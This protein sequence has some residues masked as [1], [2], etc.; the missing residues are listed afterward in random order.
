M[1]HHIKVKRD[2]EWHSWCNVCS[3]FEMGHGKDYCRLQDKAI[4]EDVHLICSF[5]T[6]EEAQKAIDF[7]KRERPQVEL[8]LVEGECDERSGRYDEWYPED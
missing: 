7:M 3:F 8:K 2:G 5:N 1:T 6:K 4:A